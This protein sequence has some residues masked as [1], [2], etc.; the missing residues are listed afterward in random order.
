MVPVAVIGPPLRPV[1]VAMLVTVPPEF[2][3]APGAHCEPLN[4]RTWP[5]VAPA[6]VTAVPPIAAELDA[7]VAVVALSAVPQVGAFALEASIA[8]EMQPLHD[9]D[10]PSARP[11]LNAYGAAPRWKR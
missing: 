8:V 10:S 11:A 2:K 5:L 9:A 4:F 6:D 1:P 3:S 7:L